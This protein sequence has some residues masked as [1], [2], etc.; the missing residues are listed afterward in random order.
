MFKVSKIWVSSGSVFDSL[1]LM[2]AGV[3]F[4]LKFSNRKS[5]KI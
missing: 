3:D 2:T 5:D 4:E 1:L